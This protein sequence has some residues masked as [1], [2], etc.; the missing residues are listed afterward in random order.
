MNQNDWNQAAMMVMAKL[1]EHD[2]RF[3]DLEESMVLARLDIARL[4][5]R[6]GL[7]GA[8][9]GTIPSLLTVAFFL[10][11]GGTGAG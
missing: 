11:T 4:Q 9:A 2:K 1:E 5:V 7:T 6:A 10:L 8:I 3:D